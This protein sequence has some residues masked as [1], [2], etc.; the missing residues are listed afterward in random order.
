M[1]KRGGGTG[2][3]GGVR[4]LNMKMR[5]PGQAR[6]VSS[7]IGLDHIQARGKQRETTVGKE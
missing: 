5:S 4:D 2:R 1:R 6:K 3:V 7:K